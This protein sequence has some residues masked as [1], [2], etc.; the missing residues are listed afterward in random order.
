MTAPFS[1]N[2]MLIAVLYVVLKFAALPAFRAKIRVNGFAAS[3][4]DSPVF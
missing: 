3:A 2:P 4:A 1:G